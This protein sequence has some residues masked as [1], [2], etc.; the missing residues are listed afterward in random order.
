[1]NRAIETCKDS[2]HYGIGLDQIGKALFYCP[3]EADSSLWISRAAANTLN[4][5]EF[6]DMRKGYSCED[7]DIKIY[8]Y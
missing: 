7:S 3:G 8:E 1:M 2:G 5:L 6:D 4:K